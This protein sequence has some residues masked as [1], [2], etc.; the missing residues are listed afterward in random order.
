MLVQYTK[1]GQLRLRLA[2][3]ARC[4]S[5]TDVQRKLVWVSTQKMNHIQI[6]FLF[7]QMYKLRYMEDDVVEV[8]LDEAGRGTLYGRLY[9]GAVVFSNDTYDMFDHGVALNDIKDSKLLNPRKRA[10]LYDYIQE[11]ALDKAV[12]F[13]TASD[14][15]RLNV[16]QADLSTMHS[17]LDML[18]VPVQRVLVDGDHWRPYKDSEGYAIVDGDA[19]YLAIAAA[20]ILAKV[21]HDRWIESVIAE[22]PELDTM[23]GLGRNMGY[24]TAVHMEGLKKYGVTSEHRKSYAPVRA[25]MGLPAK[26]PLNQHGKGWVGTTD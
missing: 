11:C 24:G 25:A 23:Y 13:A 6:V 9:V 26:E 18:T 16:L 17:A 21:S 22:K 12:A 8:G 4:T 1:V 3:K 19:Q 7:T 5:P 15:D 10:I 14:V 20:G 2:K